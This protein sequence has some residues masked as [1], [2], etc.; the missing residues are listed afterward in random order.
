MLPAKNFSA[1][2]ERFLEPFAF[3]SATREKSVAR[4]LILLFLI[5]KTSA[6]ARKTAENRSAKV[7]GE[8]EDAF[9]HFFQRCAEFLTVNAWIADKLLNGAE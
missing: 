8:F 1:T 3:F 9:V 5:G 4:A 2:R 7:A 6:L